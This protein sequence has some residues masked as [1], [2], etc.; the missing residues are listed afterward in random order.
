MLKS[1]SKD[2]LDDHSPGNAEREFYMELNTIRVYKHALL[3]ESRDR[4]LNNLFDN[5]MIEIRDRLSRLDIAEKTHLI[6][7]C[8]EDA[9]NFRVVQ[10]E[11]F[12]VDVKDEKEYK[13]YLES[14]EYKSDMAACENAD[15]N[16]PRPKNIFGERRKTSFEVYKDTKK[17]KFHLKIAAN[18]YWSKPAF[19]QNVYF[20]DTLI[21]QLTAKRKQLP[22]TAL[23][24]L[25]SLPVTPTIFKTIAIGTYPKIEE[26]LL[27]WGYIDSNRKWQKTADDLAAFIWALKDSGKYL[28]NSSLKINKTEKELFQFRYSCEAGW[29]RRKTIPSNKAKIKTTIDLFIGIINSSK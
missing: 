4:N 15:Q 22:H 12:N 17:Y 3:W 13:K 21:E 24:I 9:K 27:S 28:K 11:R 16:I 25:K 8:L 6:D 29:L 19:K 18:V 1:D 26:S 5:V 7:R 20:L 2:Y 23:P 10:I 14:G